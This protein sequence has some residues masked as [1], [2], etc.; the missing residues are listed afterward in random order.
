MA[1]YRITPD[2]QRDIDQIWD[3]V[4]LE[5]DNPVAADALMGKFERQFVLLAAHPRLGVAREDLAENLRMFPIQNYVL[6]YLPTNSG[7][8]VVQIIHSAR[9]IHTVFRGLT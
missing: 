3:Y 9:D 4:G 8:D 5:N 6:L 1:T 2:A 7:I